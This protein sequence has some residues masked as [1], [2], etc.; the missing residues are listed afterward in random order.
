MEDPSQVKHSISLFDFSHI[1]SDSLSYPSSYET[2]APSRRFSLIDL[3]S[4]KTST[5][6]DYSFPALHNF[7]HPFEI[8]IPPSASVCPPQ[9]DEG[10]V[11]PDFDGYEPVSE[12]EEPDEPRAES[13]PGHSWTSLIGIGSSDKPLLSSYKDE[14]SISK[15]M[16]W[17]APSNNKRWYQNDPTVVSLQE[18]ID[19]LRYL[20]VGVPSR[21]FLLNPETNKFSIAENIKLRGTSEAFL[22]ALVKDFLSCGNTAHHLDNLASN[23]DRRRHGL[24]YDT[25]CEALSVYLQSVRC[26]VLLLDLSTTSLASILHTTA[27]LRSQLQTV[28]CA[29]HGLSIPQ[30]PSGGHL[31]DNLFS[32]LQA[33]PTKEDAMV[34]YSLLQPCLGVYFRWLFKWI[35][36]GEIND[37]HQEFFIDKKFPQV[38]S[39]SRS[40]WTRGFV[41]VNKLLPSF[42]SDLRD[43]ILACGKTVCLL[44]IC[45]PD[46]PLFRLIDETGIVSKICDSCDSIEDLQFAMDA[47][48]QHCKEVLR[49]GDK[50]KFSGS[51]EREE[52]LQ[53]AARQAHERNLALYEAKRRKRLEEIAEKKYKELLDLKQHINEMRLQK[54]EQEKL[55]LEAENKWLEQIRKEHELDLILEQ[56]RQAKIGEF[57][58]SLLETSQKRVAL[59]VWKLKRTKLS[60]HRAHFFRNDTLSEASEAP[61]SFDPPKAED[62]QPLDAT[63]AP[64]AELVRSLIDQLDD[65]LDKTT[66][67]ETS[68]SIESKP[69]VNDLNFRVWLSNKD[70]ALK[71]RLKILS[72]GM[73]NF[74][75]EIGPESKKTDVTPTDNP[76]AFQED[77]KAQKVKHKEEIPSS[78]AGDTLPNSSLASHGDDV[79]TTNSDGKTEALKNKE[80]VLSSG[81]FDILTNKSS[82]F[83]VSQTTKSLKTDHLDYNK[84]Q[85][86]KNRDKVLSSDLGDILADFIPEHKADNSVKKA[87][88]KNSNE[89]FD[90]GLTA[91]K[92]STSIKS[93]IININESSISNNDACMLPTDNWKLSLGS[94][95]KSRSVTEEKFCASAN[96]NQ[97]FNSNLNDK[98]FNLGCNRSSEDRTDGLN[99]SPKSNNISVPSAKSCKDEL[100]CSVEME[101][102][103]E[104]S[105]SASDPVITS[106]SVVINSVNLCDESLKRDP[107]L[108][109]FSVDKTTSSSDVMSSHL[110]ELENIHYSNL[111]A[112]SL[113]VDPFNKILSVSNQPRSFNLTTALS[114]TIE[115]V[116]LPLRVQALIANHALMKHFVQT[117]LLSHLQL[118]KKHY[119]LHDAGWRTGLVCGLASRFQE[120]KGLDARQVNWSRVASEAFSEAVSEEI[121]PAMYLVLDIQNPPAIL[122]ITE[123]EV[124][125]SFSLQYLYEWPFNLIITRDAIAC[126]NRIFTF[127]LKVSY[128]DWI[129]IS[130]F[131]LLGGRTKRGMHYKQICL[132]RHSMTQFI[133]PLACF[134]HESVI[135][136]EYSH[137]LKELEQDFCIDSVYHKHGA[138]VKA[139]ALNCFL[140]SKGEKMAIALN[141]LFKYA[142]LFNEAL[143]LGTWS[144][145]RSTNTFVHSN[146]SQLQACFSKFLQ[147]ARDTRDYLQKL[148]DEG[149]SMKLQNLIAQLSLGKS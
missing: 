36:E 96:D 81:I 89:K 129:L 112:I 84:E 8:R 51:N 37:P 145:D 65:P 118:L 126:Y 24:V 144:V 98:L 63:D 31:I 75:A 114:L 76:T 17:L 22:S 30:P 128:V 7:N 74:Y 92:G 26:S 149:Y 2:S 33:T 53:E 130:Q 124:F 94:D 142:L 47:Y 140:T 148:T 70:Q 39:N 58:K 55:R 147:L 20:L 123:L 5:S 139:V 44:K 40:F 120:F 6:T 87:T 105:Y 136:V 85:A 56:T 86:I 99:I 16:Q 21:L 83:K 11:T 35:F 141:K 9:Q 116:R 71:N 138:Y 135:Q 127:L 50:F 119:L 97:S 108:S 28:S 82:E 14:E 57:Y 103:S 115:S 91:S 27:P 88:S 101:H 1:S 15:M 60:E 134:L 106:D 59:T 66:E 4:R 107:D 38:I 54:E 12:F 10:Y 68:L 90:E 48:Y 67:C 13:S 100:V 95:D 49:T 77:E 19:N 111:S 41:C 62:I 72:S 104:Y 32:E 23:P 79:Q 46:N 73:S 113:R 69:S 93:S 143:V 131:K 29:C 43:E 137:L 25:L 146:F 34:V 61:S 133:H 42:L 78:G 45:D 132:F 121:D 117:G 80:K 102:T 110:S 3:D 122:D 18:L 109:S 52:Q 64:S 125:N